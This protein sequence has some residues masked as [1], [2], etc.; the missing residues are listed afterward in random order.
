MGRLH[1]KVAVIT[2]GASGIGRAIAERFVGE[3]ASV[4]LFDLNTALLDEV[5][6]S[7]GNRVCATQAGDVTNEDDVAALVATAVDRF[8]R[9]DIGVNSAGVGGFSPLVDHPLEEWNR[10][11]GICLTGVFLSIKHEATQMVT[12]GDG[13]VIINLDSINARQPGEGMAAYCTAKPGREM[14]AKCAA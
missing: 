14:L 3:G 1:E 2:G 12:Q 5:A 9:L 11:V 13:G 7:L 6:A 4:V 10:V 8:G